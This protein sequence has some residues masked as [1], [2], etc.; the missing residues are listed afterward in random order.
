M[1]SKWQMSERSGDPALAGANGKWQISERGFTLVELIVIIS[2]LSILSAGV[3][4]LIDPVGKI[5]R[6]NDAKRKSDLSQ[7][8]RALELYYDDHQKYPVSENLKIKD[9]VIIDWGKPWGAPPSVYMSHVP[10]DPVGTKTYVYSSDLSLQSY[11][12]HASLD[13]AQD[14]QFNCGGSGC[15]PPATT[16]CGESKKGCT[17]GVSS[18]NITP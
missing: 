17:Y 13:N 5:H 8:Q 11:T 14:P 3:L 9:G 10:K 15:N 16:D 7:I 2:M 4:S 1:K 18:S 6:A 12:L